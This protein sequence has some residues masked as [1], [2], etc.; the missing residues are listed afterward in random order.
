MFYVWAHC[1]HCVEWFVVPN[2]SAEADFH[3]PMCQ[4]AARH[5]EKRR[6]PHDS[7]VA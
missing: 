7:D 4:T 6:R 5:S 1:P 2:P 3:C